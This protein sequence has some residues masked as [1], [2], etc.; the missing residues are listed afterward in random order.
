[1]KRFGYFRDPLC[2]LACALYVLNRLW[3][4]GQ[5]GGEFLV[6]YFNDVLL[7]P[8]ALPLVLWIQ[9]RLGVRVGDEPPRW[10]EIALH[11]VVWGVTA[12][13]IIPQV[14]AHATGDW[15]DV[16]AYSA[17]ALVAGCWWQEAALG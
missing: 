3:W 7:I 9:R 2:L 5:F 10:R 8:A 12:E 16:V 11:L 13:A 4:R 14:T 1:M 17:G 15:Y 6:G